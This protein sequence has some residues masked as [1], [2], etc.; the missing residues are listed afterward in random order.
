MRCIRRIVTS[1]LAGCLLAFFAGGLLARVHAGSGWF[2]GASICITAV[3]TY[4]ILV[5]ALGVPSN[6]MWLVRGGRDKDKARLPH[7]NM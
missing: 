6:R 5:P 1:L 7:P 3:M 4:R 2:Y